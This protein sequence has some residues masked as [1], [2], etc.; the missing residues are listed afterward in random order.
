METIIILA[1]AFCAG[2]VLGVVKE[3]N[4]W[5]TGIALIASFVLIGIFIGTQI[6]TPTT[7]SDYE[8][9]ILSE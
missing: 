9:L 4:D 6:A 5:L 3:E 1:L 7:P 2:I 8:P